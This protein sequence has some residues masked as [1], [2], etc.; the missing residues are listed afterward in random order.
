M[1]S[2]A[3]SIDGCDRPFSAKGFCLPHYGRWYRYGDPLKGTN[4]SRTPE[5]QF[6]ATT[7][8]V[9][10]CLEWTGYRTQWGYGQ[11]HVEGRYV[12]AHRY[13][14]QRANGPIPDGMNIDHTCHN[15]A[16]VEIAHLRLAT[17]KQNNENR[18]MRKSTSGVRGV[19]WD[20]ARGKW[21]V[22]ISHHGKVINLGRFDDLDEA[23]EVARVARL[24]HYTHNDHDHADSA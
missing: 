2:V 5:E 20:K 18:T 23:A 21:K 15:R 17:Y 14:W 4:R 8:R 6:T 24:A 22:S 13:A 11:I 10:D 3:C 9:G 1:T 16:C 19:V 12:G 7:A